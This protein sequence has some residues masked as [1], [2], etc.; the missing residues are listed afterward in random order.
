MQEY[1]AADL[2]LVANNLSQPR[3]DRG[4]AHS[5]TGTNALESVSEFVSGLKHPCLLLNVNG[6]LLFANM[7]A[8]AE[9]ASGVLRTNS[10]DRLVTAIPALGSRWASS[11]FTAV[12]RGSAIVLLDFGPE[13][14]AVSIRRLRMPGQPSGVVLV[15]SINRASAYDSEVLASYASLMG[16]TDSETEVLAQLCQGHPVDAIA[17]TRR[18]RVSTVRSHV[19]SILSKASK[20]SVRSIQALM[21]QL[22][23]Y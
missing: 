2:R 1:A 8:R 6:V 15:A 11:L 9:L 13:L 14:R 20:H 7:Q 17:Q 21:S 4:P 23:G 19:K 12:S 5:G 22:S 16:L 10:E 3:F 18:V